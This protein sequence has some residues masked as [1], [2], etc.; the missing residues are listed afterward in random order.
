MT[1][2]AL[3]KP[4]GLLGIGLLLNVFRFVLA[5]ELTCLERR[6]NLRKSILGLF[7]QRVLL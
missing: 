5:K 3:M 7:R 1:G 4:I 6:K 2:G